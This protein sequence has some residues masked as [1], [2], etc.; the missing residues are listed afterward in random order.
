MKGKIKKK[1]ISLILC[2]SI[3][4]SLKFFH[5]TFFKQ[6]FKDFYG[7]DDSV[8]TVLDEE[9]LILSNFSFDNGMVPQGIDLNDDYVFV[10]LYDS[11]K[12]KSSVIMIFDY[13][14][15]FINKVELNTFSHVGGISFDEANDLLW[16]SGTYGSVNAYGV[17]DLLENASVKPVFFDSS[18]GNGLI[19]FKSQRAVSYLTVC[20][21]KLYV[22]N[23]TLFNDGV[24]K[25]YEIIADNGKIN[26]KYIDKIKVPSCV[27]GASI[28]GDDNS[29]Y[30]SFSRSFGADKESVIQIYK[31]NDDFSIDNDCVTIELDSMLEQITFERNKMY[32][33]YE[34]NASIYSDGSFKEDIFAIDVMKYIKK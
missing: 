10:S 16:V 18:V 9:Y 3:I 32:G 34:S 23:Y 31:Y 2:F 6:N 27:Q 28:F 30:I 8:E 1:I 20:D 15:N 12:K 4:L 21:N 22:G 14:M 17:R 29:K 11:F 24:L 7:I 5:K 19:N 33:I 13:K 26:L 25:E